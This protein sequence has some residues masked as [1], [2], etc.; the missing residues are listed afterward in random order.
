MQRNPKQSNLSH[1]SHPLFW[2]NYFL[3][4][5]RQIYIPFDN[6]LVFQNLLKDEAAFKILASSNCAFTSSN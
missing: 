2:V 3:K 5:H 4:K 6:T 1:M